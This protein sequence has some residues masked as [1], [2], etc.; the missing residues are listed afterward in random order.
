MI[1]PRSLYD[2]EFAKDND[3]D[4]IEPESQGV[5]L[6]EELLAFSSFRWIDLPFRYT[7]ESFDL[8]GSV[9]WRQLVACWR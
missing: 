8:T 2:E 7:L 5:L 4:T 6:D 1:S 9:K 3:S